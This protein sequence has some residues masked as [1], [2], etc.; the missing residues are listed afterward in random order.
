MEI[1]SITVI[2][3]YG[4]NNQRDNIEQVTFRMGDVAS[5]VGQ[6]GSG[7]TT[8]INDIALF[9]NRNTPSKRRILI[10]GLEPSK[11]FLMDPSKNP[12]AYITQHTNFLSD[13]PVNKFLQIHANIRRKNNQNSIQ[14]IVDETI[15]FANQLTGEP[16]ILEKL[17]DRT[18]GRSNKGTSYC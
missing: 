17:Y 11:E 13:Y 2:H 12:I 1:E 6:T 10:N 8:L 7:K 14:E 18:I 4:K 15:D 16:I 9:A 5:I 3:G